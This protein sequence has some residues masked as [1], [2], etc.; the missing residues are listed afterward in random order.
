MLYV[1][2][3][4]FL[5]VFEKKKAI[6]GERSEEAVWLGSFNKLEYLFAALESNTQATLAS[7]TAPKLA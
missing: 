7:C 1:E 5:L 3:L 4:G 6:E 2:V